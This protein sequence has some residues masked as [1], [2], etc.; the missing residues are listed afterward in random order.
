MPYASAACETSP[1]SCSRPGSGARAAGPRSNASRP[2][3]ATASSNR[4]SIAQRIDDTNTCSQQKCGEARRRG[5]RAGS[6]REM[7]APTANALPPRHAGR[8]A[9]DERRD[10]RV[11]LVRR[12]AAVVAAEAHVEAP[13]LAPPDRLAGGGQDAHVPE[14][15]AQA[16]AGRR[17]EE[18]L[19]DELVGRVHARAVREQPAQG[20]DHMV[21]RVRH[22]VE[23][24]VAGRA[25]GGERTPGGVVAQR[26]A[27]PGPQ[28]VDEAR[29]RGV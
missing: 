17:G 26:G 21:A 23:E 25:G 19:G 6:W 12:Q 20:L 1:T 7:P 28:L 22:R 18:A 15:L 10:E 11:R 9:D 16:G 5:D 13:A 8:S 3:A 24:E 14:A 27:E 4:G 2:P 29:A